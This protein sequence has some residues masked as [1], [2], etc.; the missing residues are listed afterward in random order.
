MKAGQQPGGARRAN[1]AGLFIAVSSFGE[2]LRR[3]LLTALAEAAFK[4]EH[5]EFV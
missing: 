2:S 1:R 5:S 4:G 3:V